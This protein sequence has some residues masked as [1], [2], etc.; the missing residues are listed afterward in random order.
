MSQT[1]RMPLPARPVQQAPTAR[2]F[3]RSRGVTRKAHRTMIYGPGGIG[4]TSL[5]A[6]C[7]NVVIA[8]LEGGSVDHDVERVTADEGIKTF[9][10]LRSWIQTAEFKPDEVIC[11]DSVTKAEEWAIADVL[12]TVKTRDGGKAQGIEDY[13]YKDGYS[14]LYERMVMLLA[15][16]D[17][18]YVKGHSIILIAHS[19]D[20][21]EKNAVGEDYRKRRPRLLNADKTNVE[22]KY[23]E[24]CDHVLCVEL[25]LNVKKGKAVGGGSRTI[26]TTDTPARV[27]KSRTLAPDPAVYEYGDGSIWSVLMGTN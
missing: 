4:K 9:A 15:D 6:L 24:W 25:D 12:D 19:I 7:P 20:A 26:Y 16:L 8:D 1:L 2:V 21:A 13:G 22:A 27:A 17:R 10:D 5:A 18:L 14:Y 3:T 11:I 23:R